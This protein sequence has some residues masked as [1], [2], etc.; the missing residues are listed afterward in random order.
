MTKPRRIE[1]RML[2]A[3][4][5]KVRSE[6]AL[7]IGATRKKEMEGEKHQLAGCDIPISMGSVEC[8]FASRP[9]QN[10]RL[11][12]EGENGGAKAGPVLPKVGR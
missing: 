4:A 6:R 10:C 12:P 3:D 5:N 2:A 7:A 11:E 9:F 8:N 1:L